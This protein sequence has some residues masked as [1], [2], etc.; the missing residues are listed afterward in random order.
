MD[1]IAKTKNYFVI[2][3]AHHFWDVKYQRRHSENCTIYSRNDKFSIFDFSSV[4]PFYSIADA[5]QWVYKHRIQYTERERQFVGQ[6]L[7]SQEAFHRNLGLDATKTALIELEK[8][9]PELTL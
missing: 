3:T 4:G 7:E 9:H 2:G 8:K 6:N 1:A 5:K